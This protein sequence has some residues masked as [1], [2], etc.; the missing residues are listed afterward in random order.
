M[1]VE[2]HLSFRTLKLS[3]VKWFSIIPLQFFQYTYWLDV[4]P[5]DKLDTN[6]Y[7][8]FSQVIPNLTK[9]EVL[10]LR[11]NPIGKGGAVE[12]LKHLYLL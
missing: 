1:Y 3:S 11:G 8:V 12:V 5:T 7:A 10:S 4:G 6:D 2:G 9:L